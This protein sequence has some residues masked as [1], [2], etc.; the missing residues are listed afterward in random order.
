MS[1][2][3]ICLLLVCL[4]LFSV[5]SGLLPPSDRVRAVGSTWYVATT[6]SDSG[7]DG[8]F[9]NPYATLQKAIN[10]SGVSDT[11]Y[12]R[13]GNYWHT[14]SHTQGYR[15]RQNGT[16]SVYFTV[17]TYPGDLP[18]LAVLNGNATALASG[19]SLLNVGR[20][21]QPYYNYIHISHLKIENV[22]GAANSNY[23]LMLCVASTAY[24]ASNHIIVDNVSFNNLQNGAIKTWNDNPN[25]VNSG[26]FTIDNCTF[27]H[28]GF[29]V[30]YMGETVTFYG[31]VD[32]V[33]KN[34]SWYAGSKADL[35]VSNGSKNYKIF[36]NIFRNPTTINTTYA[37]AIYIAAGGM[38]SISAT[39]S[40]ISIYKNLIRGPFESA[41][42]V[43]SELVGSCRNI[44]IYDNIL[45]L[46]PNA[47]NSFST[48]FKLGSTSAY[49]P[50]LFDNI[51][52]KFNT[53]SVRNGYPFQVGVKKGL[54]KSIYVANNIFF[55]NVTGLYQVDSSTANL[56]DPCF[57]FFNNLYNK[58]SGM[59]NTFWW[60]TQH[61]F[62]ASYVNASARF[63]SRASGNFHLNY[64]S[65]CIDAAS[66]TYTVTKDYDNNSRPMGRGYDIGAYEWSPNIGISNP[67]PTNT[68]SITSKTPTVSI[69]ITTPKG[70]KFNYTM[71]TNDSSHPTSW[72]TRASANNQG[73]GSYTFIY[74]NVTTG[75]S[76]YWW[77]V[78]TVNHSVWHNETYWF[79]TGILT[80]TVST[81]D[82]TG[83]EE[84]N[85]TL[86]GYLNNDGIGNST[87]GLYENYPTTGITYDKIY[88]THC[89]AQSFTATA[90]HYITNISLFLA[91]A[92]T[93][94]TLYIG[95]KAVDGAGKPTGV[96]LSSGTYNA[97]S[98]TGVLT[99]T[100]ISMTPSYLISTGIK[101]ALVIKAF[102]G[103]STTNS[104][105]V[106]YHPWYADGDA[107]LST[108]NGSTWSLSAF[109]FYDYNF[110]IW[111][112]SIY[113]CRV[114]F[115]YGTTTSYVTETLAEVKS[116]GSH[117]SKNITGLTEGQLYHF[118]AK[119]VNN[120]GTSYGI[121]KTFLTKPEETT[122]LTIT[123]TGVN[124][125][126]ILNWIH[127]LGYNRTVIRAKIGSYPST[128]QSD[129][130]IY[131]NTGLTTTVNNL[132]LTPG[133]PYY[134]KAWEYT[135]WGLL[136]QF[137]DA[138]SSAIKLSKPFA[139][140]NA[141]YVQTM[142]NKINITWTKGTGANRTIIVNKSTGYPTSVTD[143]TIL[144][145]GTASYYNMTIT[146]ATYF[147][148]AYSYT[149]W[150]IPS[151]STFSDN[152]TNITAG[153]SPGRLI[154]N[155]FNETSGLPIH[156]DVMVTNES[157]S[158]V[159]SASNI[160]GYTIISTNSTPRG[161]HVTVFFASHYYKHYYSSRIYYIDI[162]AGVWYNLSGYLARI[163]PQMITNNS[164]P[165]LIRVINMFNNPLDG[166]HVIVKGVINAYGNFTEI[167]DG[168]TDANGGFVA[169]LIPSRLYKVFLSK[170]T[171]ISS[172]Q[173]LLPDP[174]F[175][176]D[177]YPTTY[178]L[179]ESDTA[180]NQLM[181]NIV[182]TVVPT[183]TSF[184]SSFTIFYNISSSD[185]MLQWYT[186]SFYFYNTTT[187]T[188][189]LLFTSNFSSTIGGSISYV[190]PN[191]TGSYKI[192]YGFKKTGFDLYMSNSQ[193][194]S[195]WYYLVG[196]TG[197]DDLL[198]HTIGYSPV[199]VHT[200]TGD[201]VVSWTALITAVGML[202][203]L[204]T[205]SPK[206]AGLGVMALGAVL[207][208]CKGP[209]GFI[210]D[211]LL[212]YVAIGAIIILGFLMII[213]QNKET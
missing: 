117:F 96:D 136:H 46:Y 118:R 36:R 11:I 207:G 14:Y 84:T 38:A 161:E 179:Y 125:N 12:L 79:T 33:I 165:Y 107:Y 121:D 87:S 168:Y 86:Q 66:S 88:S 40:N 171:F 76:K 101:Y 104:V 78:T 122:A 37:G 189:V 8:S 41:I 159:Y 73:N 109:P 93:P 16:S 177:N 181:N 44:T 153:T 63:N 152:G 54:L 53:V 35:D 6:G 61:H 191:S 17:S 205:F 80:P 192:C 134:Y 19:Y 43:N 15:L 92:G 95:L 82:S 194:Y 52:Y 29:R 132:I 56:T 71:R 212:S 57:Y 10:V 22:S 60:L 23:G 119:A 140:T 124:N 64:T 139:P 55:T 70:W 1:H 9:G 50:R 182:L 58:S 100:N 176:G 2:Q 202:F 31:I 148:R 98:L 39:D 105:Y 59:A 112:T 137:S 187:D 26:N 90:N 186:A 13:A 42:T 20:V 142:I 62:E 47:T 111:G 211:S 144:Y 206:F 163:N 28:T 32:V 209:L 123:N 213:E 145:N 196:P 106:G 188:W 164:Y 197:L 51:T 193:Y 198:N 201:V 129:T 133:K 174:I 85:S 120:N 94:N 160:S 170:D 143:G 74:T 99:W 128:P 180:L 199:Y 154:V 67:V 27:N 18:A 110:K 83:V 126:Q 97:N 190:V 115:Q 147:M 169:Y 150:T 75:N 69:T 24:G 65:P 157:G 49:T 172:I 151:V 7:G 108:N 113:S 127:G 155:C 116:T 185:S 130:S 48:G 138:Y 204:F 135:A 68:S 200:S 114:N 4:L 3:R 210:P 158:K 5:F 91:K 131:N 208:F 81:N 102:K 34:N 195:I 103:T 156:F 173:N 30:G 183:Y 178:Y 89:S 45:D 166:V 77:K 146:G 167:S 72:M 184:E 21:S 25:V 175:Y 203:V 149:T 162:Y 141:H